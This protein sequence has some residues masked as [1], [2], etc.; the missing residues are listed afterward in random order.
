MNSGL[1]IGLQLS[2]GLELQFAFQNGKL[3]SFLKPAE[4]TPSILA[5]MSTPGTEKI[6]AHLMGALDP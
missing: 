1:R 4:N 5:F 3:Q 2:K 6:T